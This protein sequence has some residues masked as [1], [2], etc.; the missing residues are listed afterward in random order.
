M[1]VLRERIAGRTP[2]FDNW[3]WEGEDISLLNFPF[4]YNARMATCPREKKFYSQYLVHCLAYNKFSVNILEK[5]I[6]DGYIE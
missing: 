1:S 4:E 6:M 3:K 2:V 5:Y